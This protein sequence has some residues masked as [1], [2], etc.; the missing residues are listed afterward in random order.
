MPEKANAFRFPKNVVGRSKNDFDLGPL[1][2]TILYCNYTS[3]T[4]AQ[5][6]TINYQLTF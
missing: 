1:I 2:N 3:E 4:G 5:N 6:E